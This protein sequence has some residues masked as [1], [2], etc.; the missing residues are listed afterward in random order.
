MKNNKVFVFLC[1]TLIVT[2]CGNISKNPSDFLA[3]VNV[4]KEKEIRCT[5][6]L[7]YNIQEKA[8]FLLEYCNKLNTENLEEKIK[9]EQLFFCVFPSNFEEME[10]MFGFYNETGEGPLYLSPNGRNVI[11]CFKQL[12]SISK[13][14]YYDKYIDICINGFWQADNIR[15]GFGIGDKLKDEAKAVC[16]QLSKKTDEEIKSVFHF[17]FEGPHP[18]NKSNEK[19][20][21]EILLK[22]VEQD[23][24]LA[25]ILEQTYKEMMAK[26][27]SH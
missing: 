10:Y 2:S 18:N 3:N 5:D 8:D 15:K 6:L 20:Y 24:R 23:D 14:E 27:Y 11:N 19:L 22:V 16:S 4:T 17:I 21:E 12:T 26:D 7:T 9:T 25:K 13:H 1:F